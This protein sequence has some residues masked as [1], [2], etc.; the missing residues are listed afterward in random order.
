M[1]STRK[2]AQRSACSFEVMLHP[3]YEVIKAKCDPWILDLMQ[4]P[5]CELSA[6]FLMD[7]LFPLLPCLAYPRCPGERITNIIK[8]LTWFFATDDDDDNPACLGAESISASTIISS[9]HKLILACF[10]HEEDV[11]LPDV[12]LQS[13]SSNM[14]GNSKEVL[15]ILS[16]H[17]RT[18]KS[19]KLLR[20]VWRDMCKDM[21]KRLQARIYEAMRDYLNGV[22]V[23]ANYR[24]NGVVPTIE[25]YVALRRSASGM[26][27][28]FMFIEYGL[29]MEL[30]EESLQNET[31]QQLIVASNDHVSFTNDLISCHVELSRGDE[32]NLPGI[33][34]RNN[35]YITRQLLNCGSCIDDQPRRSIMSFTDAMECAKGFVEEVDK[36]CVR[37]T[38]ELWK[39]ELMKK[40]PELKE[41]VS[42]L[43]TWI[44]GFKEWALK[45]TK[46][47]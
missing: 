30:D 39:S 42:E 10:S 11:L 27:Y 17:C 16:G 9:R 20:E 25:E 13:R 46:Y 19:L 33:I 15:G 7:C 41:Y 29:G 47:T 44:A 1:D 45:T 28:A 34:Y 6:Q 37:L 18:I 4:Q 14:N 38:Q 24:S 5:A 3:Q 26:T 8:F 43:G 23:Q 36:E 31:L 35:Q 22:A 21:S 40:K 12:P 32:F 2:L